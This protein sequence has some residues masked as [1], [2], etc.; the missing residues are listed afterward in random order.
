MLSEIQL[1]QNFVWGKIFRPAGC[2]RHHRRCRLMNDILER[3]WQ[4]LGARLTGPM[5]LRLI[6]QPT[7][8]TILD[9]CRAA[10][11]TSR[12][13]AFPLGSSLEPGP[14]PRVVATGM[15]R[16]GKSF[17]S[18]DDSG[19]GLPTHRSPGSLH[20]GIADYGCDLG[21]R[22]LR[23]ASRPDQSHRKNGVR[24]QIR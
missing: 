16:R 13:R 22:S 21:D 4:N 6:I 24:R 5:N 14:P 18:R 9:S 3:V 10:G 11:R 19:C 12:S 7:V 23:S 20:P 17:L 2:P 15:E 1:V 8:A